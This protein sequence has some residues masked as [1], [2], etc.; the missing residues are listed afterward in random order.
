MKYALLICGLFCVSGLYAQTKTTI[1]S[2]IE[3]DNRFSFSIKADRKRIDDLEQAYLSVINADVEDP[4][5]FSTELATD[6]ISPIGTVLTFN[7]TRSSLKIKSEKRNQESIAE[8]RKWA[9]IIRVEMR[10]AV[11]DTSENRHH[12]LPPFPAA[13]KQCNH[14]LPPDVADGFTP[15]ST[16][17]N[18]A[19]ILP[20]LLI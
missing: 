17:C 14:E 4:L 19:L 7:P 12:L 11:P 10:L 2:G 6:F 1:V 20:S 5:R 13:A 9:N 3:T 15:R 16:F 8:A 18:P